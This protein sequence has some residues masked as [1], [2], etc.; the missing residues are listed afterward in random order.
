M[1]GSS[2]PHKIADKIE[3]A[4]AAGR[5]DI[6]THL[7]VQRFA[8]EFH[9]SRSPVRQA[10]QILAEAGLVEHRLN[11]G[12]FVLE[13][14]VVKS[15]SAQDFRPFEERNDYQLIAE[16]WL[17]NRLPS[18]VTN[19]FLRD[20]YR[21]TKAQTTTLMVRAVREGWAELKPGYGW[22]FLP[23]AKSWGT[24]E[25]I[26]RFRSVIEPAAMLEPT[27]LI[28]RDVLS[29][30]RRTQEAMLEFGIEKLAGEEILNSSSHLHEDIVRFSGNPL[31]EQALVKANRMRRL[32]E[33]R[34][35]VDR[36]QMYKFCEEHLQIIS[37]LEK[38]A[39]EEA[40]ENLRLHLIGALGK[41]FPKGA[42]GDNSIVWP[43]GP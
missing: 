31:F 27:F 43:D 18:S 4:I 12:F 11:R 42:A 39:I 21:L 33:Y 40:S 34:S 35:G 19:Q 10:M 41:K 3:A 8:D 2:L 25:Q 16:D 9:V 29:K 17:K 5:I 6:Y 24:F 15:L 1:R 13:N 36:N 14:A 28:Q 38:G 22:R 7:S 37:L 23:V 32:L 26:Y 20:R 30:H